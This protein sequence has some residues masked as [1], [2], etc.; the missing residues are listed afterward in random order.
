MF[1]NGAVNRTD[2][3]RALVQGLE[4]EDDKQNRLDKFQSFCKE[5]DDLDDHRERGCK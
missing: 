3:N 1:G 4:T 5:V 2:F